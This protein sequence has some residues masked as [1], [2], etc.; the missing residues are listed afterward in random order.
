[1]NALQEKY[2]EI[3][4]SIDFEQIKDHPNIIN[5]RKVLG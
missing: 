5:C 1:M 2:L 4:N 3:F